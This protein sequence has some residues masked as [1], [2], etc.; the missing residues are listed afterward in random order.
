[1]PHRHVHGRA[2]DTA[3]WA[4]RVRPIWV[5]GPHECVGGM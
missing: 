2:Q 5:C 4:T 3:V 1:M